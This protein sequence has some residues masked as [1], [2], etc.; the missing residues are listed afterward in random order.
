MLSRFNFTLDRLN[1][2]ELNYV[3][4]SADQ[5]QPCPPGYFY[6]DMG[7]YQLLPQHSVAGPDCGPWVCKEQYQSDGRNC[8]PTDVSSN[9]FWTCVVVIMT[10]IIA[11][12]FILA[13]VQFFLWKIP[14][15]A[16]YSEKLPIVPDTDNTK[17]DDGEEDD[18]EF[19]LDIE[20]KLQ[21]NKIVLDEN[22]QLLVD[23]MQFQYDE[24]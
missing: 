10:F 21:L 5:A 9:L 15:E 18:D 8:I 11:V 17:E 24:D 12:A 16:H 4:D 1:R 2:G 20:D 6:N 19:L 23:E 22:S 13:C 3:N 7:I 14:N